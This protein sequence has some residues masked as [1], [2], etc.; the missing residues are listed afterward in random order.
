MYQ[1]DTE[2][3][4]KGKAF[5]PSLFSASLPKG[6]TA[7]FKSFQ[8]PC[9]PLLRTGGMSERDDQHVQCTGFVSVKIST[10]FEQLVPVTQGSH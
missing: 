5:L 4:G 1:E 8:S 2:R 9:Y 10:A 6:R 7:P 3:Q